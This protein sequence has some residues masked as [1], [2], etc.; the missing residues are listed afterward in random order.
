[1][2]VERDGL[3]DRWTDRLVDG[4]VDEQTEIIASGSVH[5]YIGGQ[6][7]RFLVG[8]MDK[9]LNIHIARQKMD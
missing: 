4:Q 9:Q 3:I 6:T 1:M 7:G 8:Q 2:Q 5:G